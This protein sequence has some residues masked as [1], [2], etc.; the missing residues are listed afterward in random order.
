V[1]GYASA[2]IVDEACARVPVTRE[3]VGPDGLVHDAAASEAIASAVTQLAEHV[4][5]AAH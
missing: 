4:R 1:L 3:M 2:E 5:A